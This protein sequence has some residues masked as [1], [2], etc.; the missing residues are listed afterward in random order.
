M[1][2]DI[3]CQHIV[4]VILHWAWCS[5]RKYISMDQRATCALCGTDCQCVPLFHNFLTHHYYER[6]PGW[7]ISLGTFGSHCILVLFLIFCTLQ[8]DRFCTKHIKICL[9]FLPNHGN[10][11]M[12]LFSF[13]NN[14]IR[15]FSFLNIF[16]M[17]N[18]WSKC[19]GS[20]QAESVEFHSLK[21]YVNLRW[22]QTQLSQSQN[23]YFFPRTKQV[24]IVF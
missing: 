5:G 8:M 1:H 12:I 17:E 11:K 6:S 3:L 24:P 23:P 21:M 19:T 9:Q 20:V 7:W 13:T 10:R 15:F 4:L 18:I 16:W 14:V 2:C 22:N